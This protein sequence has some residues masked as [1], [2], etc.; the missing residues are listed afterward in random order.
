MNDLIVEYKTDVVH[1]VNQV[2]EIKG[3]LMDFF[4][5]LIKGIGLIIFITQ[6]SQSKN[7]C[8]T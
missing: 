2:I 5:D 3:L 6:L 4:I 7:D 8:E 1:I